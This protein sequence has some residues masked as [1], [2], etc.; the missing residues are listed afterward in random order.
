MPHKYTLRI[1]I[2]FIYRRFEVKFSK[3]FMWGSICIYFQ[4]HHY[5][6]VQCMSLDCSIQTYSSQ[7]HQSS[8]WT[9]FLLMRG[10]S[11]LLNWTSLFTKGAKILSGLSLKCNMQL[12]SGDS[13]HHYTCSNFLG[14]L[15]FSCILLDDGRINNP[16]LWSC[17][18]LIN[19]N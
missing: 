1:T 8:T 19:K 13:T 10:G 14:G 18:N 3:K 7:D 11:S 9:Y 17:Q 6:I 16:C 2:N 5:L 4:I 12:Q 15:T